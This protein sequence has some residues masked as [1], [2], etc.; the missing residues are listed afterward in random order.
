VT[1]AADR[2]RRLVQAALE[3]LGSIAPEK[4]EDLPPA[5]TFPGYELVREIHRGGQGVVYLA[6]QLAT[7]RRVAIKLMHGGAHLGSAGRAR[8]EREVQILGQLDHPGIVKIHDSGST[9]DGGWYYVMDYISGKT[10]EEMIEGKSLPIGQALDLF[11]K[12]SEAIGAAH[13]RGVIHRDLK[14][15]NIKIRSNG[16]PVIVDFGLAKVAVPDVTDEST[17]R[18]MT[19]T[20]QFIGSLPWASPEQ[21]DGSPDKIDVRTDVY[22]LGVILFQMLTGRFPYEVIGNMRDVLDNILRAQPARP[23]TVRR[24]INN[25]VETIVLKCLSKERER[26]YQSAGELARDIKRYLTGQPIEAKRDSGWYVIKKTLNRHKT[27]AGVAGAFLAT[28]VV[29]AGVMTVL[30]IQKDKAERLAA[31]RLQDVEA[32]RAAEQEQRQRAESNLEVTRSL[33]RTLL[34]DFA[35]RVRD[36]RGSTP[37]RRM[38]AIEALDHIERLEAQAQ[39]DPGYQRDI[40]DAADFVGDVQGGAFV[41]SAGDSITAE[42]MYQR[43][44]E[45][46][47]AILSSAPDDPTAHLDMAMSHTK[48]AWTLHLRG[49]FEEELEER[50][51]AVARCNDALDLISSGVGSTELQDRAEWAHAA[52]TLDLGTTLARLAVEESD[53]QQSDDYANRADAEF[54]AAAA[55]YRT[56]TGNEN[57]SRKLAVAQSQLAGLR[58]ERAVAIGRRA[59]ILRGSDPSESDDLYERARLDLEAAILRADEAVD[60]F[61]NLSLDAPASD[62][63]RRDLHLA[64]DSAGRARRELADLLGEAELASGERLEELR[65]EALA[66]SL[67]QLEIAEEVSA[68]DPANIEARRDLALALNKVGSAREVLGDF[69]EASDAFSRSLE[70]RNDL[71]RTDRTRRHRSDLVVGLLKLADVTETLA[72]QSG[73]ERLRLE[74]LRA[75]ERLYLQARDELAWMVDEGLMRADA[76][77]IAVTRE[78]LDACRGKLRGQ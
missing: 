29:F 69:D 60:V 14:P 50:Q 13:L 35:D 49:Q 66:A 54:E 33:V 12:I 11:G 31:S 41:E 20:G 3:G 5:G 2:E 57:A 6:I 22:S 45:I 40:A 34:S 10:L 76:R 15:S 32:A 62:W 75:A 27:G 4:A 53:A 7:K 70:V 56:Q 73:A 61:R 63:Y 18:L 37:V 72:E 17:P 25:E 28:L 78:A 1:S 64:L 48:T 30:Y 26:R 74:G 67:E 43:A 55:F 71:V 68:G 9:D 47:E 24:Q 51:A 46:R 77:V 19:M 38:L 52:S 16:E 58:I 36:L 65:R 44:R 39:S 8:F 59:Q 23:S 42:R 21:A